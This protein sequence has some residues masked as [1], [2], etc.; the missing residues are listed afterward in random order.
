MPF[1]Q[2]VAGAQR[3]FGGGSR[4]VRVGA[5]AR[6]RLQPNSRVSIEAARAIKNAIADGRLR[7]GEQLPP[8]RELARLLGLSRT[9]LRDALK[10]LSGMGLVE[11]RRSHGVFVARDE[12]RSSVS[13]RLAQSLFLDARPFAE[14]F[15]VR[16]ALET[17]AAAWAAERANDEQLV[18][19]AERYEAMRRRAEVGTLGLD[20]AIRLDSE[21]HRLIAQATGNAIL[22]RIM[23]HLRELLEQSRDRTA[24]VPGRIAGT[25]TEMGRII[26]AVCRKDVQ[27]AELEMYAHLR[28]GQWAITQRRTAGVSTGRPRPRQ[29][30]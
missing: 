5:F 19:L 14:L 7:P 12:D 3:R 25:V 9:S 27:E 8:E 10:L 29:A 4:V 6:L 18:T 2:P 17:K 15:E 11:V 24:T 1:Q 21:L 13:R 26:Q 22:V 28:Q 16:L 20:E 23:D 30:R